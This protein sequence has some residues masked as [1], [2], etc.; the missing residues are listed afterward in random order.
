M[1]A[2][3]S[4]STQTAFAATEPAKRFLD[5]FAEWRDCAN[6]WDVSEL[7]RKPGAAPNSDPNEL[8]EAAPPAT[9]P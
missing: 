2:T 4:S 3:T 8:A 1:D 9:G 7:W 6:Q 5:P